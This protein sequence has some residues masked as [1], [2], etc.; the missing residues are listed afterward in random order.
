MY[1]ERFCIK[2]FRCFDTN[3][4]TAYFNNGVNAI[5]GENNAG[6][7]ALIDALRIAFSAVQY[8]RDI[9]F[10]KS[11]FH[12]A[13]SGESAREAQFDLYFADVPMELIEIWMPESN[14][15]GEFHI[16]FYLTKTAT[17][18]EKVKYTAWGGAVEG[19]TLS[20]DLFDSIDIS[21]LGALRDAEDGLRPAR[22]SKLAEL[23]GTVANTPEKRL[24]LVDVLSNANQQLLKKE[25]IRRLKSIINDNLDSIEQEILAQRI[26]VGFTEPR[27]DAIASSIRSWVNT[28]WVRIK[29]DS[30]YSKQL[31]DL[32][33]K[34][35]YSRCIETHDD[36]LLINVPTFLRKAHENGDSND[37]LEEFLLSYQQ[38]FEL[39]QNGLGY[40]NLIYMSTILG[41]MSISKE[42]VYHNLLLIEEPEAHLHPQLQ[43]LIYDFFLKQQERNKNIQIIFTTHSPTLI[44]KIELDQINL[45]YEKNHIVQCMPMA[46]CKAA[47]IP[48]DK[49]HL[50]KYLDVTKSQMFF[51]KG[52]IFV[53]GISEAL[54]LSDMADAL[55]RPLDK[56]AVEIIN[57]DSLS[58]KPFAHLLY[59]EDGM[60]SFCKATIITDD[61]RCIEKDDNYI[62]SELDFDGDITGVQEKLEKGSVS[63][64]FSELQSICENAEILLSGATKTLEYELAFCDKNITA[65]V[66][67]LKK[68]FPVVGAKLE[69]KVN[70]CTT[71]AEKQILVWLFIRKRDNRKGDLAQEI[72]DLIAK[73][74]KDRKTYFVIP[75][76]LK[77]SIY[78]VTEPSSEEVET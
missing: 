62:D 46:A 25:H 64:R 42:G 41:D 6:K 33:A 9:Y 2:N 26:D 65:M 17:G 13:L 50:K 16:R 38:S 68:L 30:D 22:N 1:L 51:A 36:C 76:Y 35:V 7:T 72:G 69:K 66:S 24:E 28:K 73:G 61:D 5:I 59:R 11:D 71:T 63:S 21:Y 3:G 56:Y 54:L 12:I 47:S 53:E 23:L 58:F 43:E 55:G 34:S 27:F 75:E 70:D 20:S 14:N 57:V 29:K 37:E 67:I 8:Q 45:L 60:P 48:A 78:Y 52:L 31:I 39:R 44:S 10:R 4:I 49:K 19:N 15:H 40:N 32:S 74:I 18:D 77:R